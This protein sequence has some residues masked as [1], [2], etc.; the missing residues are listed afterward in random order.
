[1]PSPGQQPVIKLIHSFVS[2]FRLMNKTWPR[3]ARISPVISAPKI[4]AAHPAG[5]RLSLSLSLSPSTLRRFH[6]AGPHESHTS[7]PLS[8]FLSLARARLSFTPLDSR[9]DHVPLQPRRNYRLASGKLCAK[10]LNPAD[11]AQ[12]SCNKGTTLTV[13]RNLDTQRIPRVMNSRSLPCVAR[14][15]APITRTPS[16]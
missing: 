14:P 9:T 1:M 4:L 10:L 5:A 15:R 2:K 12:S 3:C 16:R 11:S 6:V 7:L 13:P 8:L